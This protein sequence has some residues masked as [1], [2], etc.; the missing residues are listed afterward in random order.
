MH[1]G[2]LLSYIT[3]KP[4]NQLTSLVLKELHILNIGLI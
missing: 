1:F 3:Q 2:H 4:M